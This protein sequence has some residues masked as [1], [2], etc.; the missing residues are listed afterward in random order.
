[1]T[2]TTI[3]LLPCVAP[4]DTLDFF[5]A[6]GFEVTYNQTRP[7]LYLS[8]RRGDVELHYGKPPAGLDPAEECSGGCLVMTDDVAGYHRAFSEALRARY[9]KV[10]AKGR[11]RITRYRPGQTRFTTVDPSGNNI[12]FISRDEPIELE[13]GGSKKLTGL[14][15]AIDNARILRDFKTDH[16]AAARALD[17][18]LK[19]HRATASPRDVARALANRAE[20]AVALGDR[21]RAIQIAEELRNFPLTEQDRA[22]L[23]DD[24]SAAVDLQRWLSD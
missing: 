17:S 9:G 6:L 14:A 15:K 23:A 16:R 2:D 20:L 5:T 1:M 22:E 19:R 3:P 7:Y 24:L 18:A 13:Y 21:D 12:V 10:L 8:L 4:G 11:P